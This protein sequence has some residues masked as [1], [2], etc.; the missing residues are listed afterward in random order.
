MYFI[1][2][3]KYFRLEPI[4]IV[5]SWKLVFGK[6]TKN[7]GY[8]RVLMPHCEWGKLLAHKSVLQLQI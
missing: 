4:E 3:E 7:V 2:T 5:Y 1:K 8:K 6:N